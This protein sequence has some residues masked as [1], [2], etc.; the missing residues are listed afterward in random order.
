MTAEYFP[1]QLDGTLHRVENGRR[2]G[3]MWGPSVEGNWYASRAAV[4]HGQTFKFTEHAHADAFLHASLD[5][6]AVYVD[7]LHYSY[8]QGKYRH[9]VW[10]HKIEHARE[11]AGQDGTVIAERCDCL[12]PPG[13]PDTGHTQ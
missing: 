4:E 11:A 8:R 10:Y 3:V 13:T 7:H 1:G 6:T 2:T 5:T 9:F 12:T